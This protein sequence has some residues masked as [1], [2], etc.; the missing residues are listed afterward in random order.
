MQDSLAL[1]F[2][3]QCGPAGAVGGDGSA[4]QLLGCRRAVAMD[5]RDDELHL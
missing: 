1:V 5:E 2:G 3:S 4:A